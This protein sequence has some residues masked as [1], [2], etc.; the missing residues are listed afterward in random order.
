MKVAVFSTRP[1]DRLFL[2]EANDGRLT[3]SFYDARLDLSTCALAEDC[4]ALC[5][6]VNDDLGPEVLLRLFNGK[7]RMIALRCTGFNN[8][9]FYSVRNLEFTVARV[10]IYSPPS[11]SE[12]T[13]GLILALARKIC[14]AWLRTREGNFSLEG[15]LGYNICDRKAGVYGT[16]R[17]GAGVA[18]ILRSMDCDVVACDP[19]ENEE[20]TKL[21]V[22]YVSQE[23]LFRTCDLITLHCPLTK[24]TKYLIDDRAIDLFPDGT[25]LINTSRGGLVDTRA[26][27]RG[28]KSGK[29]SALAL[30]VYEEESEFFF[31]D[32]SDRVIQD[33]VLA[34]I[35]NF[36]NVIVTGHQAFFTQEAMRAI[37]RQTVDNLLAFS[38]GETPQGVVPWKSVLGNAGQ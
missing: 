3:F 1:Y 25:M 13:I 27:I 30:D 17:I 29:I 10:P 11:I 7:T 32:F 21:G 16:G 18:K 9:D 38:R 6:F 37:A 15:L 19:Y 5:A 20:L 31:Q 8:V 2:E 36:P 22:R 4:P 26:V 34:R 23:E 14:R 33:D 28:L 35:L 24:E 12:Y